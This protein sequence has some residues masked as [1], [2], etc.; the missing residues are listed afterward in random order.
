MWAADVR[1][2]VRG[3]AWGC[4]RWLPLLRAKMTCAA[5]PPRAAEDTLCPPRNR[6]EPRRRLG[7]SDVHVQVVAAGSR[8]AAAAVFVF[9]EYNRSVRP[10]AGGAA[11]RNEPLSPGRSLC[12]PPRCAACSPR[13]FRGGRGALSKWGGSLRPTAVEVLSRPRQ[14]GGCCRQEPVLAC[15]LV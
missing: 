15:G 4:W 7:P 9:S 5:P 1:V 6:E 12:R 11:R 14:V 2:R 13:G 8:D 3:L 10:G